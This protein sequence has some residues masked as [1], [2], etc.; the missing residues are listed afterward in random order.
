MLETQYLVPNK[1]KT[2]FRDFSKN[3][4]SVLHLNN[5]FE[6]E[7]R[8]RRSFSCSNRPEHDGPSHQHSKTKDKYKRS[9]NE[10]NIEAFN[11]RLLSVHWDKIKNCDDPN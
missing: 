11:H 5:R 10:E 1:F 6:I 3:S 8:C 7:P 4:F 2:N 9:Y